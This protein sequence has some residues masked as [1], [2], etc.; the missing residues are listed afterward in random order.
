MKVNKKCVR[1]MYTLLVSVLILS[2]FS[3]CTK[4]STEQTQLL[5]EDYPRLYQSLFERDSDKILEFTTSENSVDL[6]KQAWKAL[7]STPVEDILTF[8]D[9]VVEAN[10]QEAWASLWY[11]DL[12][13]EELEKLHS[14]WEENPELRK[15]IASVLG[16]Q[17]TEVS[18]ELLLNAENTDDSHQKFE[19]ALAIGRLSSQ[20]DLNSDQEMQIIEHAFSSTNSKISKAYLYGIYRARKDLSEVAKAQ[21]TIILEDVYPDDQSLEQVVARMLFAINIDEALFRYELNEFQFMDVQL[22]IEISQNLRRYE[23][24]KHS[25]VVLNALLDHIN[26]NVRIEALRTIATK[27]DEL[28]G[29]LDNA[30]LNKIGLIRGFQPLLRLEALNA[31]Q[32][33]SRYKDIVIELGN[34]TPYN[35]TIMYGILEKISSSDEMLELLQT[36]MESEDDLIRFYALRQLS[37]WWEELE[38][39]VKSDSITTQVNALVKKNMMT[40]SRSMIFVMGSLFNDSLLIADDEFELIEEMLSKFKLPEDIEVFQ[41]IT[42]VLKERFEEDAKAFIDSLAQQNNAALNETIRD[43]GWDIPVGDKPITEFRTPEWR[44]LTRLGA[45]PVLI[46][47]TSKGDIK[48][49]MDVLNAPATISGLQSLIKE[50]EYIGVPFHRVVPNFVIQGGDIETQNGFGGPDYVVPTEASSEQYERGKVGIASAGTDT[51]G[52][53]FFIMNQWHPHLNGRYTIIGT[54]TEGMEV[55]DRIVQGDLIRNV[56]WEWTW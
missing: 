38:P 27:Q 39:D 23:L 40:A 2:A 16:L 43:Q 31:I 46:L 44:K 34:A 52:S 8:M 19:V 49:R 11:K 22:A 6:Q 3:S 56:T 9:Y 24:T 15:G 41:A 30:V 55:A 51:E 36:D 18:L 53:Q 29:E 13:D 33:P 14:L 47:D 45:N 21:L 20:I 54:V 42:S 4:T 35:R 17:G 37:N 10:T 1:N 26:H 12:E 48:I 7:I 32:S 50:N 25:K 5:T 28:N